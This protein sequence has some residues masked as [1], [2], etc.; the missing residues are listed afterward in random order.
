MYLGT[1]MGLEDPEVAM[2]PGH[3]RCDRSAKY[4]F[5]RFHPVRMLI[6]TQRGIGVAV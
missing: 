3:E 4:L 2:P 1:D 6:I 5:S